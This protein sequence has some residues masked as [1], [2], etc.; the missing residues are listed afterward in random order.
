MADDVNRF[1][2]EPC[3]EL[4]RIMKKMAENSFIIKALL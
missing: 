2:S 3:V 4:A 1:A